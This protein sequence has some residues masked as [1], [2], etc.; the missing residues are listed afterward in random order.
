MKNGHLIFPF[1][2]VKQIKCK[3]LSVKW[4]EVILWLSS[5]PVDV[6]R[7]ETKIANGK[8]SPFRKPTSELIFGAYNHFENPLVIAQSG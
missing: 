3:K 7:L 1:K 4:Y 6:Y 2:G 8:P 5:S